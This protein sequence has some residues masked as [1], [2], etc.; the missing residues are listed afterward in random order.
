MD[1]CGNFSHFSLGRMPRFIGSA[2]QRFSLFSLANRDILFCNHGQF[3]L[4][5]NK[6]F[7]FG[8]DS[9]LY[10]LLFLGGKLIVASFLLFAGCLR[11]AQ[12]TYMYLL[13]S[14]QS[15]SLFRVWV[16]VV[17]RTFF[18]VLFAVL[19]Y[20]LFLFGIADIRTP[21]GLYISGNW[22]QVI[23]LSP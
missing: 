10:E 3:G 11:Q 13:H 9:A 12:F 4:N 2:L 15:V 5:H 19:W 16:T 22:R 8:S 14:S 1:C 20:L 6:S 21:F 7:L 17:F 23:P 18:Y